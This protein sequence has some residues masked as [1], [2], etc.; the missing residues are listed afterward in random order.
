MIHGQIR[1]GLQL[2]NGGRMMGSMI[3]SGG[4]MMIPSSCLG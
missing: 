2:L 1:L 3:Q 4:M